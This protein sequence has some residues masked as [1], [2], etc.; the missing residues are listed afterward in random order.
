MKWMRADEAAAWLGV[1]LATLRV[2]AHRERWRRIRIGREVAYRADDVDD[3]RERRSRE[4][5]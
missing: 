2:L 3:T 5:T 4:A 1:S